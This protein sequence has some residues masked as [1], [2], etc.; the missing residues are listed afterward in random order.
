ME[1]NINT[2]IV[3]PLSDKLFEKWK[4]KFAKSF[5]RLQKET[6]EKGQK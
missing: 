6:K 2:K 4:Q 3:Q 1:E 5:L